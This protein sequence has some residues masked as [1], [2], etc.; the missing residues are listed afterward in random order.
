MRRRTEWHAFDTDTPNFCA[1]LNHGDFLRDASIRPSV[2]LPK[3]R[4]AAAGELA[5]EEFVSPGHKRISQ[6]HFDATPVPSTAGAR[7]PRADTDV[8]EQTRDNCDLRS[9]RD[10]VAL[11]IVCGIFRGR[12]RDAGG[13]EK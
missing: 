12:E 10:G 8:P 6:V 5:T 2:S 11:D 7:L 9:G 1:R 4:N 13:A 3:L